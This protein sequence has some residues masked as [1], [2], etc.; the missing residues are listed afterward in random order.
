MRRSRI[1]LSLINNFKD[2]DLLIE[3]HDAISGGAAGRPKP[4][5]EVLKRAAIILIVA[6]WESYIEDTIIINFR[7]KLQKAKSPQEVHSAFKSYAARWLNPDFN[8]GGKPS[9]QGLEE[10]TN[11]GWKALLE[12]R[13][14]EEITELNTPNSK[15]VS[16]LLRRY[17]NISPSNQWKWHKNDAKYV[18]QRLDALISLRG[19]ISH[20][21]KAS[22]SVRLEQV[23]E[24]KELV[25]RIADQIEKAISKHS[26][27]KGR[28]GQH[29]KPVL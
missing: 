27:P 9:P 15:N 16:Q 17:L 11:R 3:I 28:L 24:A 12:K 18:C 8:Q 25:G 29:S 19:E 23:R 26:C 1:R 6:A 4:E 5:L 2:V 22:K 20:R 13:C 14:E 10:W 7:R 21:M